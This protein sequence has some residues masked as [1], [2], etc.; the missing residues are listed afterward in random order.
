MELLEQRSSDRYGSEKINRL[1]H[2][3]PCAWQAERNGA[4]AELITAALLHDVGHLIH[5]YD[6]DAAQRGID[7]RHEQI[8][9]MFLA[10]H[11]GS[12]VTEPIALHVDAKRYLC[13]NEPG[14]F[15]TLSAGSVR[16]L[17][18]QGGPMREHESAAFMQHP[19]AEAALKLRRWDEGAKV[20]DLTTPDVNYFKKYVERSATDTRPEAAE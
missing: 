12:A 5:K 10:R 6:D 2:A 20:E 14:Y 3:L 13:A 17:N 19:Y 4:D 7:A 1:A 16:S 18:L 8:G 9:S 11:F 15:E